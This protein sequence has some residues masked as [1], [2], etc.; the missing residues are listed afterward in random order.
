MDG[1]VPVAA[2]R[3]PGG[4]LG[5][6]EASMRQDKMTM[7]SSIENRVPLLDNDVVDF[8]LQLPEEMLVRFVEDS[9]AL[10]S[11]NPFN[12]MQGK[13]I[14]KAIVAKHFG[15]DFAFR[16]KRIMNIDDITVVSSSDF[17]NYL[18]SVTLPKMKNRGL[19]DALRVKQWYD[20]VSHISK[21]EFTMMWRAISLETWCELFIDT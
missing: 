13:F 15:K 21:P 16:T 6:P 18:Y 2:D 4:I 5:L 11:D 17:K 1:G 10:L 7:A 20:N 9:P 19:V 14:L 3:V 12:W 8:L